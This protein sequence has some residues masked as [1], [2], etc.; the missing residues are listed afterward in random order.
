MHVI[1]NV[2][3]LVVLSILLYNNTSA[4]FLDSARNAIKSKPKFIFK[5]DT[6][7]S[8]IANNKSRIVGW[9]VGAEFNGKLRIGGGISNLSSRH[10]P[11]LDRVIYDSTGVDTL[12]LAK[13]SFSY[14]A[15]FVDYVI[16]SKKKWEFSIPIQFGIGNS[17]YRY[18]DENNIEQKLDRGLIVL[19]EPTIAGHYKLT[20]WFGLGF[21]AGFRWMIINNK[22]I[23]SKFNS[24]VYVFKAK[25][26]LSDIFKRNNY[27]E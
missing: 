3:V 7:N 12:T 16:Y 22:S 13:L 2:C 5:L 14:F 18:T 1:K 25:L 27:Q 19:Y 15:Y 9:K 11:L 8:F 10:S 23:D 21:G 20:K 4:Q 6:R 26:F 24:A 17:S